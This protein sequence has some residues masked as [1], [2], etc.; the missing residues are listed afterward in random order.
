MSP[1]TRQLMKRGRERRNTFAYENG[2]MNFFNF[3]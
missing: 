1:C 3:L 2:K